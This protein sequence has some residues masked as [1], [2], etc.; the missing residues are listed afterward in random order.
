[1]E[2]SSGQS[3]ARQTRG[4]GDEFNYDRSVQLKVKPKGI[5]SCGIILGRPAAVK[6][7]PGDCSKSVDDS[8]S[9]K[10]DIASPEKEKYFEI[11]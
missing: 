7:K 6:L 8:T 3:L 9:S 5:R 2:F 11:S 10:A 4:K 1:M